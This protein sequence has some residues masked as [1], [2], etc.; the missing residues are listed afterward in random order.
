MA[1]DYID[2]FHSEE[3]GIIVKVTKDERAPYENK[4][5]PVSDIRSDGGLC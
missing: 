4:S 2:F 3:T 5:L 1:S